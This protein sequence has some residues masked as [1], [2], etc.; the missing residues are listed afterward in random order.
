MH[1]LGD[2]RLEQPGDRHAG[3]A[4]DDLGDLVG[5]DDPLEVDGRDLVGRAGVGLGLTARGDGLPVRGPGLIQRG[6]GRVRV[7]QGQRLAPPEPVAPL[8]RAGRDPARHF[9][10]HGRDP[11]RLHLP[12]ERVLRAHVARL[13]GERLGQ[14]RRGRREGGPG[15]RVIGA[16]RAAAEPERGA[17]GA[18]RDQQQGDVAGGL[19][20]V[21]LHRQPLSSEQASHSVQ[22]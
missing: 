4:G 7:E 3:P 13:D 15:R 10:G 20:G 19:C 17:R 2:L 9:G 18:A 16:R 12:A 6:P 1:E 21:R 8:D 14:Q 22:C 5:V 11:V